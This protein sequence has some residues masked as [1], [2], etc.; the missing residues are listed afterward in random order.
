MLK[1][2]TVHS[3]WTQSI[4]LVQSKT[5]LALVRYCY[6]QYKEEWAVSCELWTS[7]S[8]KGGLAEF[9]NTYRH[10]HWDQSY[11]AGPRPQDIL[12]IPLFSQR[13]T[14]KAKVVALHL[15]S[16][17]PPSES[18]TGM[19]KRESSNVGQSS[20]GFCCLWLIVGNSQ[21]DVYSGYFWFTGMAGPPTVLFSPS[22]LLI[23]RETGSLLSL[24]T[25]DHEQMFVKGENKVGFIN[26]YPHQAS[27]L[28]K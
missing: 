22:H 7:G 9:G 5:Q 1:P 27:S 17:L 11:L 28:L 18:I 23:R 19:Q 8:C 25:P 10:P 12:P 14:Y 16:S 20:V 6:I 26:I 13:H 3:V 15:S 2:R 24:L 4:Y 21:L